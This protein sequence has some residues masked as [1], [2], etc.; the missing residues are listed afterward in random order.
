VAI[1]RAACACLLGWRCCAQRAAVAGPAHP[2]PPPMPS[3]QHA[4]PAAARTH[5]ALHTRQNVTLKPRTGTRP[6][7]PSTT[8]MVDSCSG[9]QRG[10]ASS[11]AANQASSQRCCGT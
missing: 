3:L 8:A 5:R 6:Q 1:G 7:L 10:S 9:S 11:A 2:S 4:G